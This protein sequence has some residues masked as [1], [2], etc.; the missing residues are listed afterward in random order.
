MF[1]LIRI[2]CKKVF[3]PVLLTTVGLTIIFRALSPARCDASLL[4]SIL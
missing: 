4:E 2:E 1:E 3:L